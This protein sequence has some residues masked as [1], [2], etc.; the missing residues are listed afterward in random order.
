MLVFHVASSCS[1]QHGGVTDDAPVTV[2][3][4][5]VY[6]YQP[7]LRSRQERVRIVRVGRC[8]VCVDF[9]MGCRHAGHHKHLPVVAEPDKA[10]TLS[11]EPCIGIC[12]ALVRGVRMPLTFEIVHPD[13][14]NATSAAR[15]PCA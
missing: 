10:F 2:G 7:M 13:T 12:A 1:E 14:I 3:M 8:S 15:S 11:H 5:A 9:V 6:E 4:A